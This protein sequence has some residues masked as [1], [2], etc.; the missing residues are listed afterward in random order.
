MYIHA[1]K[2]NLIILVPVGGVEDS[3]TIKLVVIID[4]SVVVVLVVVGIG[5]LDDTVDISLTALLSDSTVVITIMNDS[6]AQN[7]QI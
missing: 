7:E 2:K 1:T 6:N 4:T 3:C 5:T